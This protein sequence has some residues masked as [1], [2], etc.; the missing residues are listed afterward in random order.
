[1]NIIFLIRDITLGKKY[2][3]KWGVKEIEAMQN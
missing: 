3:S 2:Q 1:M